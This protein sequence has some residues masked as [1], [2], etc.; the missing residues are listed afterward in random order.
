MKKYSFEELKEI[1]G[2]RLESITY[3]RRAFTM[4]AKELPENIGVIKILYSGKEVFSIHYM[5]TNRIVNGRYSVRGSVTVHRYVGPSW[6]KDIIPTIHVNEWLEKR[7]GDTV[8]SIAEILDEYLP[9]AQEQKIIQIEDSLKKQGITQYKVNF[10]TFLKKYIVQ[11]DLKSILKISAENGEEKLNEIYLYKYMSLDAYYSML[12]HGTFRMNS[13]VSMNDITEA[14]WVN[15]LLYGEDLISKEQKYQEVVKN[16]NILISSFSDRKDDPVMWRLYGDNGKG[17]CLG[18]TINREA[19]TKVHYINES[20]ESCS[21]LKKIASEL[22]EK[23]I[24]LIYANTDSLRYYIKSTIYNI[25]SEYRLVWDKEEKVQDVAMYNGLLTPCKDFEYN[26]DDR[27]FKGVGL[28]LISLTIGHNIPNY[29]S[30]YPL[31]IA[32]SEEKFGDL[33][34]YPSKIRTFR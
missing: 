25:E 11:L 18:F 4:E 31:L 5:V 12:Q 1:V 32:L 17:V 2:Q 29:E 34:A 28:R 10:D 16:R 30:N 24:Q 13:I 26:R 6:Y 22:Y 9:I 33:V 14:I 3:Q 7:T 27:T 20:D 23:N 15:A 21:K 19:V 8:K